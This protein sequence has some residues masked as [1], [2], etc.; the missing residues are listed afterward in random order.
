MRKIILNSVAIREQ[1]VEQ[2]IKI[3]LPK[4]A[5]YHRFANRTLRCP[6]LTFP[7]EK[8]CRDSINGFSK[9]N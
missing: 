8:K 5:A 1:S 3:V 9:G 4:M 2:I 6:R 7:D